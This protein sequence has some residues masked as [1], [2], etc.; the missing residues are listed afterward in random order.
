M[1]N[2]KEETRCGSQS[3]KKNLSPPPSEVPISKKE[4]H[5]GING[6]FCVEGQFTSS[7]VHFQ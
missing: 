2:I 4:N 6:S 5:A 1:Y 3:D 7:C